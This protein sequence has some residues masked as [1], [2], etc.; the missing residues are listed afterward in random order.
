MKKIKQGGLLGYKLK[1]QRGINIMKAFCFAIAM[2]FVVGTWASTANPSAIELCGGL[3]LAMAVLTDVVEYEGDDAGFFLKPVTENP[4]ITQMGFEIIDDVVNN[5][6]IYLNTEIDKITKKR[7][8]CGW[9]TT[10]DGATIYRKLINPVDLQV[11]LEQCADVFDDTVFRKQL[12]RGVDVND[13]TGTEIEALL[14]SFVEPVITRDA[15][16]ILWLADTA[17]ASTDYSMMDGIYKK[18]AAGVISDDII[19]AGALTSTS[20]NTSNIITTLRAIV[21]GADRKLRQV[22]TNQKAL[23]VTENVWNGYKA[24]MQDNAQLES[25][26]QQTINGVLELFFDGIQLIKLSF[27]DEY[28][29]ADFVTGSPAAITDPIRIVYMKKDNIVVVLDTVSRYNEVKFWYLDKED[30][31]YMRARYMMQVEYKYPELVTI[32][33]F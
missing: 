31:N 16:R 19:D 9:T 28:L 5:K 25:S 10:G 24:W 20:I 8:G 7:V 3:T 12:K 11:Q 6:Y 14:L 26:K 1:R 17:L 30:T 4:L 18:L 21:D 33:G 15:L 27:V 13:L 29:A 32:A 23:Y 22:P 2:L